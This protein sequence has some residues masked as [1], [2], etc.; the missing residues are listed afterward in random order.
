MLETAALESLSLQFPYDSYA[1]LLHR[2]RL[3]KPRAIAPGSN[4]YRTYGTQEW[5]NA[6]KFPVSRERF[7]RD[8]RQV[9]PEPQTFIPDPGDVMELA[10]SGMTTRRQ[11]AADGFVRTVKN[12]AAELMAFD[13]GRPKPAL[14]DDNP[15]KVPLETLRQMIRYIFEVRVPEGCKK[16]GRLHVL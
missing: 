4:G 11:S 16:L 2:A 3:L 14:V 13:P 10:P 7:V 1:G 12:D 8:I 15:N 9:L 6:Y 5:F